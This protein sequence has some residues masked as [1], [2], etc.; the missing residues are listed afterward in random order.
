MLTNSIIYHLICV[1]ETISGRDS[2]A[3]QA[4]WGL[5]GDGNGDNSED[6]DDEDEDDDN[7]AAN[8]RF[9]NDRKEHGERLQNMRAG[10]GVSHLFKGIGY[11]K[12][13][14]LLKK[15]SF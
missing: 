15:I 13:E 12:V 10:T 14:L 4:L 7:V 6:E 3:L 1:L 11:A 5:S 9:R 8:S 2:K